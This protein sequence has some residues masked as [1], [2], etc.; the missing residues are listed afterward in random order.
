V[1]DWAESGLSAF[2]TPSLIVAIQLSTHNGQSRVLEHFPEADVRPYVL[3]A[4]CRAESAQI[5]TPRNIS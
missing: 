2:R 3:V 1:E 4:Y 5:G